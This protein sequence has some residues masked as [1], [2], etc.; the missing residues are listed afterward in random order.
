MLLKE[1][2]MEWMAVPLRGQAPAE[3]VPFHVVAPVLSPE[4]VRDRGD[5][6]GDRHLLM[7][8]K[9]RGASPDTRNVA[10]RGE[11]GVDG[12]ST[13]GTG[14]CGASPLPRGRSG[15]E[16]ARRPRGGQAPSN[17]TQTSGG[18]TRYTQ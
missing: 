8:L 11:D 14:T 17:V 10:E 12:C 2:G 1:E 5:R 7:L 15:V 16:T 4:T 9:L 3:P 13:K 6:E 18:I